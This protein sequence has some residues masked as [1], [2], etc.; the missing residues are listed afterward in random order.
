MFSRRWEMVS[1]WMADRITWL[2]SVIIKDL[3]FLPWVASMSIFWT[4][5]SSRRRRMGED[6]GFTMATTLVLTTELP[7]PIFKS[8]SLSDGIFILLQ[9]LGLLPAFFKFSLE[10]HSDSD[11]I[12]ILTFVGTGVNFPE[13]LL[14]DEI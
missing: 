14:Q 8:F 12:R 1:G 3:V 7:N 9:V 10:A 13:G 6:D 2:E 4:L 11:H 5:A